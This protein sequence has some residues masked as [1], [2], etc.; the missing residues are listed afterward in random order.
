MDPPR[1]LVPDPLLTGFVDGGARGAFFGCAGLQADCAVLQG[2]LAGRAVARPWG[3]RVCGSVPP[4]FGSAAPAP[5]RPA[6][7]V[8]VLPIRRRPGPYGAR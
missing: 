3:C 8:Y 2:C 7:S 6:V 1:G 4:G 5:L